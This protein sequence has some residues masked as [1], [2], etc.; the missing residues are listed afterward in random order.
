M[1]SRLKPQGAIEGLKWILKIKGK[2]ELQQWGVAQGHSTGWSQDWKLSTWGPSRI[3]YLQTPS[4]P[5]SNLSHKPFKSGM[6][7]HHPQADKVRS[8]LLKIRSTSSLQGEQQGSW[9][10]DMSKQE[11]CS[12]EGVKDRLFTVSNN[13]WAHSA[14]GV[15]IIISCKDMKK[16]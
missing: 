4:I 8:L 1:R 12:S 2:M 6:H 10:C 3:L 5:Q 11:G 9:G 16:K 13:R 15:G 7:A 14:M